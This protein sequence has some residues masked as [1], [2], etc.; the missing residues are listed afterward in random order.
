MPIVI[1]NKEYIDGGFGGSLTYYRANPGDQREVELTIESNIRISSINNPITIDISTGQHTSTTL[2]WAEE[3]FRVGDSI[4]VTKY[5]QD[6]TILLTFNSSV[7]YVDDVIMDIA[8][9]QTG[10]YNIANGEFLVYSVTGRNR[11]DLD[12]FFNHVLNGQQGSEFSLI[13]GEATRIKFPGVN[14]LPVSSSI[15]GDLIQNQSG[16]FVVSA[17]LQRVSDPPAPNPENKRIYRLRVTFFQPGMYD[18]S[19]FSSSGCLK[20]YLR[21]SWASI[22]AEPFNRTEI[23]ISDDADTGYYDE[24]YNTEIVN[25]SLVQGIQELDYCTPSTHD[26]IVDGPLT[27][28]GIGSVYIPTDVSYYKNRPTSQKEITMIKATSDIAQT[29]PP[30]VL[31]SYQNEFNAG[32]TW[33][34]NSINQVGSETTINVTF[35]PNAAFKTFM[36]DRDLGDRL[37]YVWIKI[38]DV[39]VLAFQDQLICDVDV[40]FPLNVVD[41]QAF[42]DH[43]DNVNDVTGNFTEINFDT[44]DDFAFH[45]R[46]LL[47]KDEIFNRFE[48]NIEAYNL[49]TGDDFT[50][51]SSTFDFNGVQISNDGRYLLNES[52][53]IVTT[54]P[55]NSLKRDALLVL[56]PSLDTM[57][58]YGIRL[59][60]PSLLRWQYWLDQLNA[61]PDF[62][63]TQDKN[64]EQYDNIGDW[65]VRIEL[66]LIGPVNAYGYDQQIEINP[67]N[68]EDN[69]DS[70]IEMVRES[71]GQ[72]VSVIV[73]GE[74][75]RIIAE[76]R[77]TNGT[78]WNPLD[79]WGMITCET[80]ESGPRFICSSVLPFDNNLSNPLRPLDNVQM[81]I[82]YPSADV[83]RMECLFDSSLV[84]LSNGIKFTSKIKGCQRDKE[85]TKTMTDGTTKTT[86]FATDKTLAI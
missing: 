2:S 43:S 40:N 63:P 67:Y 68:N 70:T 8:P 57:T 34:I 24:A 73:E 36:D 39:N 59:Y 45:G 72:V 14:A 41:A 53:T 26:I 56:D 28:I 42:L 31:A 71:T 80:F 82:T 19:W 12:V 10:G 9:N 30:L 54:L 50:L 49:T 78:L 15:I 52:Q 55:S 61:S 7:L 37:F 38:G 1:T 5:A 47:D 86:T 75:M 48:I 46:F 6:G 23:V 74:I 20:T 81:L 25:G 35:T 85:I 16:Q 44:E 32:Y 65:I 22:G 62:Y 18:S 66:K 76:H 64:W 13:D 27:D 17:N 4:N 83:A 69:I 21:L 3:G 29:P 58:E 77:I 60:Y 11:D 84:D 79:N 51:Q 33:T